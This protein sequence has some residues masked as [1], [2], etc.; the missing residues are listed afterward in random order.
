MDTDFVGGNTE[1]GRQGVNTDLRSSSLIRWEPGAG[2]SH[3][4]ARILTSDETLINAKTRSRETDRDGKGKTPG[5]GLGLVVVLRLCV[6]TLI[7]QRHDAATQTTN[8]EWIRINANKSRDVRSVT[9]TS[10]LM[11]I[12]SNGP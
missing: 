12:E 4:W 6:L 11:T 9:V 5:L 3:E 7:G 8:R 10:R 1:G 2:R